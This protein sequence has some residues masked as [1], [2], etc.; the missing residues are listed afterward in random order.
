M[1]CF[2][3]ISSCSWWQHCLFY[4]YF[5]ESNKQAEQ[6]QTK[7]DMAFQIYESTMTEWLLVLRVFLFAMRVMYF[8]RW[9]NCLYT[10]KYPGVW[11]LGFTLTVLKFLGTNKGFLGLSLVWWVIDW[12][13]SK[14]VSVWW[15]ILGCGWRQRGLQHSALRRGGSPLQVWMPLRLLEPPAPLSVGTPGRE[16][17]TQTLALHT[18]AW[19]LQRRKHLH[20]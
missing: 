17:H 5:L 16:T 3:Q 7:A 12:R 1:C 8:V 9:Q 13:Q 19:T 11:S 14:T 10:H 18:H 6:T 20:I 2:Y 15:N 4:S